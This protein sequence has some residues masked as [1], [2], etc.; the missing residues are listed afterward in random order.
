MKK[1]TTD[2]IEIQSIVRDYYKQL[3][4]SKTDNLAEMDKF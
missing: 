4:A 3:C 1:V 2:T